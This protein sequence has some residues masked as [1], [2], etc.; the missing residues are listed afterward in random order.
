M[1][2]AL[3]ATKNLLELHGFQV[4][5]AVNGQSAIRIASEFCPE[6]IFLDITLPDI[7]G[8]DV[9]RELKSKPELAGSKFIA[10]SGHG[11]EENLRA[12]QAGFDAYLSKPI[13]F[14]EMQ[15]IIGGADAAES[16]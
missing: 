8:Y 10:V 7:S 12:R 5:T 13:D 1:A 15:E 3:S 6:Y 11:R 9:L 2:V 4:R 14:Q 16:R